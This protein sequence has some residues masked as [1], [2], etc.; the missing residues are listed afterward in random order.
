L[1]AFV[2]VGAAVLV[3][4]R[5]SAGFLSTFGIDAATAEDMALRDNGAI[6]L[7]RRG[8]TVQVRIS[9]FPCR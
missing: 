6:G 3:W 8:E 1:A 4:D 2:R 5:S 9:A 7:I